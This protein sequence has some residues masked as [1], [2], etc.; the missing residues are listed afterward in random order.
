MAKM[1]RV[2]IVDDHAIVRQGLTQIIRA[3]NNQVIFKESAS[4]REAISIVSSGKFDLVLLDIT[5]SDTH[6][7]DVLKHMKN[8]RP[9]MGVIMLSMHPEELYAL[10]ALKAGASGYLTKSCNASDLIDAI[11]KV[12]SGRK[13]ITPA[14]VQLMVDDL[15]RSKGSLPHE[16]LSDREYQ[17]LCMIGQGKRVKDI[18]DNLGLSAKSVSTYRN[19]VLHKLKMRTNEQLSSYARNLHLID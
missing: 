12:S 11:E 17:I 5:L 7:I 15:N 14:V 10:R 2:L 13:Y 4:G 3:W 6:G 8:V 19:R 1:I 16:V 18:A 9:D